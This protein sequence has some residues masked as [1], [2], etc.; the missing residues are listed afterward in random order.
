V[1]GVPL[2]ARSSF[3]ARLPRPPHDFGERDD[4][5]SERTAPRADCDDSALGRTTVER[6]SHDRSGGDDIEGGGG[7]SGRGTDNRYTRGRDPGCDAHPARD[8][9][10][11]RGRDKMHAKSRPSLSTC[12]KATFT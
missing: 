3:L 10:D 11:T 4:L 5:R 12:K 9:R 6:R 1:D 7:R 2:T 8:S